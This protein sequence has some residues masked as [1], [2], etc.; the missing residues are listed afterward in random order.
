MPERVD[1]RECILPMV[2]DETF[3]F[4]W[5][6]DCFIKEN[7]LFKDEEKKMSVEFRNAFKPFDPTMG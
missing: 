3:F 5:S 6:H 4:N 7:D 2:F 1:W